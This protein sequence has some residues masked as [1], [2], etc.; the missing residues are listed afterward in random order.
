MLDQLLSPARSL[1]ELPPGTDAVGLTLRRL[2]AVTRDE[3]VCVPSLARCRAEDS[4]AALA[5]MA[6]LPPAG[7]PVRMLCSPEAL[8]SAAGLRFLDEAA[9]HGIQVRVAESPLHELVMVDDRVALVYPE[10]ASEE[11]A[12]V[13]HAPAILRAL[14]ALFTGAW[15]AA[16]DAVEVDVAATSGWDRLT[17]RILDC[18]SAGYKDDVAARRLGVS[19]RTYRR[20]VAD[21]M[22]DIG[23]AS[24]FQAGARAAELRLLAPA[25]EP[26]QP[27]PPSTWNTEPV[28]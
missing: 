25:P 12:I 3:L 27:I 19:V 17:R 24:R 10:P 26:A 8:L 6:R 7:V 28:M 2:V 1:V 14:R 4:R 21:I 15:L 23:A 20:Y 18:L 13:T 16:S 11:P 22:R 9:G 5:E